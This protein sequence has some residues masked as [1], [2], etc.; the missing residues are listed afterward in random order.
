MMRSSRFLVLSTISLLAC[1]V[2]QGE[3]QTGADTVKREIPSLNEELLIILRRHAGSAKPFILGQPTQLL[4]DL[5]SF[6]SSGPETSVVYTTEML[7]DEEWKRLCETN[8]PGKIPVRSK[9]VVKQ[10]FSESEVDKGK[11]RNKEA[12]R[13]VVQLLIDGLQNL[14]DTAA[15]S[16]LTI[17]TEIVDSSQKPIHENN[18]LE[19]DQKI[20]NAAIQLAEDKTRTLEIRFLAMTL[21][22][23]RLLGKKQQLLSSI[24]NELL[25]GKGSMCWSGNRDEMLRRIL[26]IREKLALTKPDESFE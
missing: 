20:N 18:D 21:I 10:R 5:H 1:S 16:V 8:A 13:C 3:D 25:S 23:I 26:G 12:K 15:S 24:E 9:R 4:M 7:N 11:A 2:C 17:C 22:D 14:D 6:V 19:F